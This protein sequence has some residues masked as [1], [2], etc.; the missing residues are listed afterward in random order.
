MSSFLITKEVAQDFFCLIKN[1]L[2]DSFDNSNGNMK[3]S[4]LDALIF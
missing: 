1:K 4:Y 2:Q 3:L